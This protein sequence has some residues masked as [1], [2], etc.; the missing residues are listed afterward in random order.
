MA[1]P[2]TRHAR[3]LHHAVQSARRRGT[4]GA[5]RPRA[6]DDPRPQAG[7]QSR[8]RVDPSDFVG[9]VGRT[10]AQREHAPLLVIG[11]HRWDR[12]QLGRLG[13]P[14][15]VAAAAL[16]RVVRELRITTLAGLAAHA[17]EIGR[18]RGLGVTAYWTVLAILRSAGYDIRQVHGE[19]VTYLTL[20]ARGR[21]DR[22]RTSRRSEE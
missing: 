15:P 3:A 2:R 9:I 16:H 13:C 21:R 5:E 22:K 4:A 6:H 7:F 8:A 10:F 14:H 18:Y 19:D 11:R 17:S 1:E 12:W 20:K